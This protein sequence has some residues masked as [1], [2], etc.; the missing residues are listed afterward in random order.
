MV[1]YEDVHGRLGGFELETEL[2]LNGG[3]EVRLGRAVDGLDGVEAAELR[4]VR[5]PGE[6]EIVSARQTRAI[7]D[8]PIESCTL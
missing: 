8:G 1:D 2:L 4:F 6:I 3:E 5:G 7:D